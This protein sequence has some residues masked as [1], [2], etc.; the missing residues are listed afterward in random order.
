MYQVHD[1]LT[2]DRYLWS[3]RRNFVRLTP[4]RPAHVFRVRRKTHS[5]KDFDYYL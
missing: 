1:L 5:E 4:D 3:G 2:N